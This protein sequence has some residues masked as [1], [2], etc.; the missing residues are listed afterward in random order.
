LN[1]Y[2][3]TPF[4]KNKKVIKKGAE[5]EREKRRRTM[6]SRFKF[7]SGKYRTERKR[8]GERLF[9]RLMGHK[10]AMLNTLPFCEW[11]VSNVYVYCF[12]IK[13]I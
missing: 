13:T 8:A 10:R 12:E 3:H 6:H 9:T 7:R 1:V 11:K 4:N 5:R 2:R